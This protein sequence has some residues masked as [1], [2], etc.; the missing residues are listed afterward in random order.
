MTLHDLGNPT[1]IALETFRK[2]GQGVNTP[3]W[4]VEENDKLYGFS[5]F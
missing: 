4:A 5:D 1:Y 2:N 3:V